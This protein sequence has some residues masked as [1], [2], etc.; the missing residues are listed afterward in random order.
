MPIEK[1]KVWQKWVNYYDL[2]NYLG[3]HVIVTNICEDIL[4]RKKMRLRFA[5]FFLSIFFLGLHNI[6]NFSFIKLN[7][8]LLKE[9]IISK[10]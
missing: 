9:I 10:V 6:F 1:S 2:L 7:S 3:I 5:L 4:L 8:H